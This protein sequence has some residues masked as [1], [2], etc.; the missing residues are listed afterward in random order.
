MR[1]DTIGAGSNGL[2]IELTWRADK[3]ELVQTW[4]AVS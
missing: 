4:G 1:A 2:G 3:L